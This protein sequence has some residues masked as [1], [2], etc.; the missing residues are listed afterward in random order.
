MDHS[1]RTG[2]PLDFDRAAHRIDHAVELH[3]QPVAHSLD[4]PPMVR[5]DP[6]LE[7]LAQI[8]LETGART[9]LVGLAQAAIA[10]D[11]GDQNS[12]EPTL[13]AVPFARAITPLTSQGY[14]GP[15]A[16]ASAPAG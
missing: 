3:Q 11:I 6:R 10:H 4:Q 7:D 2:S 1:Q 5:G 8:G 16:N 9:F 13:H 15:Q 14:A 12:G